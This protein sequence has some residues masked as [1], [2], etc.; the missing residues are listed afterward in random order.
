MLVIL[1]VSKN[2]EIKGLSTGIEMNDQT[3]S[4]AEDDIDED[5]AQNL[6]EVAANGDPQTQTSATKPINANNTTNRRVSRAGT[7]HACNQC[8][9]QFTTEGNLKT[10]IQ[11]KHEGIKYACKQCDYQASS[12]SNLTMHKYALHEGL[13]YA[14]NECDYQAGFRSDLARHFKSKH[15]TFVN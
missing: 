1:M 12:Q 6:N 3:T 9:K 15:L 13:K 10:H 2:L 5:P 8:D 11:S 7:R 14:C 4:N